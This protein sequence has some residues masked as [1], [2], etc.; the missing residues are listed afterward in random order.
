MYILQLDQKKTSQHTQSSLE[1]NKP[2]CFFLLCRNKL[3]ISISHVL[4]G[5]S[6]DISLWNNNKKILVYDLPLNTEICLPFQD[7]LLMSVMDLHE[8]Y[9]QS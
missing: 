6:K 1:Q 5:T 3:V 2:T 7:T 8:V 4:K 9:S